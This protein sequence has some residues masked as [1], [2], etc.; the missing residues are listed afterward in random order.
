MEQESADRGKENHGRSARVAPTGL[1]SRPYP[2]KGV[3]CHVP[4]RPHLLNTILPLETPPS[5]VSQRNHSDPSGNFLPGFI[6]WG[7]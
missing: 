6:V 4:F 3:H 1:L 2:S 5:N 7:F